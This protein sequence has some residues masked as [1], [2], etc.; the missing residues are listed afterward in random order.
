MLQKINSDL[1]RE[2]L[3]DAKKIIRDCKIG[4]WCIYIDMHTDENVETIEKIFIVAH[5]SQ[6]HHCWSHN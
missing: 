3:S 5:E 1:C 2:E 6:S 4:V